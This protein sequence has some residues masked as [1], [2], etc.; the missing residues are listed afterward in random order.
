MTIQDN[1]YNVAGFQIKGVDNKLGNTY[2]ESAIAAGEVSQL[3][4]AVPNVDVEAALGGSRVR[5]EVAGEQEGA[6]VSAAQVRLQ[7]GAVRGDE[8]SLAV[9]AGIL[10]GVPPCV[11]VVLPLY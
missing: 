8:G 10:V 3:L 11:V 5:A 1:T 7:H 2:L 9:K 6:G 4:V